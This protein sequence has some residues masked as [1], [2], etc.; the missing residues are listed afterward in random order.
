M[1]KTDMIG[2]FLVFVNVCILIYVLRKDKG[3]KV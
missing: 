2:W 3:R 1:D